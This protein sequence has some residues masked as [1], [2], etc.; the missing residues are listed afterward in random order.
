MLHAL[1]HDWAPA[2]MLVSFKLETDESIL[3]K[4]VIDGTQHCLPLF[5]WEEGAVKN[6]SVY[7]RASAFMGREGVRGPALIVYAYACCSTDW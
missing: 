2:C 7:G 1:R 3:L 5:C 4:K 6:S